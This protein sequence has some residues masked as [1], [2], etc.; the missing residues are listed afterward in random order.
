MSGP[1]IASATS[2]RHVLQ[3]CRPPQFR[4]N[5]HLHHLDTFCSLLCS[6]AE[7]AGFLPITFQRIHV[8]WTKYG[9]TLNFHAVG[10][11]PQ[12][13]TYKDSFLNGWVQI[14]THG[15]TGWHS[16]HLCSRSLMPSFPRKDLSKRLE[17]YRSS[18]LSKYEQSDAIHLLRV[19]YLLFA[20]QKPQDTTSHFAL[21]DM[22]EAAEAAYFWC[23]QNSL[24]LVVKRHPFCHSATV[25]AWIDRMAS[26]P[27]CIVT[28]ANINTLI[29][30]SRIVVVQNSS[31]GFEAMMRGK[32]VVT[33]GLS[34][35]SRLNPPALSLA[36]LTQHLD[37]ALHA[38]APERDTELLSFCE[39]HLYEIDSAEDMTALANSLLTA[40]PFAGL[41]VHQLPATLDFSE[42]GNAKPYL[43][44]GFSFTE[45]WGVWTSAD[46]ASIIFTHPKV[47]SLRVAL[48]IRAYVQ[49]D[50]QHIWFRILANGQL[51][52]TTISLS[53]G[54][55]DRCLEVSLPCRQGINTLS[56][57]ILNPVY[58][59]HYATDFDT[60]LLGLGLI[61]LSLE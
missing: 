27:E 40:I 29:D 24:S 54:E 35:Y 56:F 3:I 41:E 36:E 22:L 39:T 8:P 44:H 49:R 9:A 52:T 12:S 5:A 61:Q 50:Y 25:A 38:E 2:P 6:S 57:E 34:E 47:D 18:G 43:L 19:P 26:L 15:H 21:C 23:R 31:V 42:S 11:S 53:Y 4:T 28:E 55:G 33:F 30:G 59:A 45:D 48:T 13:Y 16:S 46:F 10:Y 60:R 20:L 7:H 58:P 51:V 37:R 1:S 14:D 17:A 32:P